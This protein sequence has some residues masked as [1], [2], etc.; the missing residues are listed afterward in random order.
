VVI[1]LYLENL[2]IQ[3]KV[4]KQWLQEKLLLEWDLT[5]LRRV[6]RLEALPLE[7]QCLEW[8]LT[9]LHLEW[10]ER[11]E[12]LPLEEQCL[13]W[14]LMELHL[15]WVE[16]LEALPL[17]EQCL[18]WDPDKRPNAT[19]ALNSV[20]MAPPAPRV[21]VRASERKKSFHE[22]LLL[23]RISV[24]EAEPNAIS[25]KK[26]QAPAAAKVPMGEDEEQSTEC[27]SDDDQCST[28]T[29]YNDPAYKVVTL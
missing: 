5:E 12:V 14:E 9:E 19:E 18:E 6:E 22:T 1:L 29:E 7:E 3:E 25:P 27:P 11:L 15:E 24:N 21:A 28:D 10:V 17:E 13:E 26:Q 16:R 2:Y 20:F 4:L 8:E 23:A